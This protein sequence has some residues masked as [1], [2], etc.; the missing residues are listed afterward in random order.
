MKPNYFVILSSEV[1]YSDKITANEKI[2]YA[3]IVT[4]SDKHGY[5]FS[6]NSYFAK[7]YNTRTET[8]SRWIKSLK[9]NSFVKVEYSPID[10]NGNQKRKIYPLIE[11][12]RP[13]DKKRKTPSDL[14]QYPLDRNVKHNNININNKNNKGS[15]FL[16]GSDE[17]EEIH[18]GGII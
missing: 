10:E 11:N 5:C 7:L 6:T 8:I 16:K 18:Y 12:A 14:R 3:E 13:L 2:L 17:E 15:S 1:R 4:L 9:D